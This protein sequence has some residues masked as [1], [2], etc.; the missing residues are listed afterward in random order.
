MSYFKTAIF[1][2]L[3][4][5]LGFSGLC[6]QE[7]DRERM[8]RDLII[9]G[10]ILDELFKTQW[11]ANGN[12]VRISSGSFSFGRSNHPSGT[13]LQDYGVVFTISGGPPAFLI[14]SNRDEDASSFYFQ[15]ESDEDDDKKITEES[16]IS[17]MREFLRYYSPN[18]GQLDDD[19]KV[20][21]IYENNQPDHSAFVRIFSS[22]GEKNNKHTE[23]DLPSTIYATVTR[24]DLEAVKNG[25]IS[26]SEF[27]DR[28]TIK[29][30]EEEGQQRDLKIMANILKTSL[31]ETENNAF[32]IRGSANSIYIEDLGALFFI[33][34][35]YGSG[36][37]V[38]G[39]AM[40]AVRDKISK[41]FDEDSIKSFSFD[42]TKFD[43][44]VE[45]E[46]FNKNSKD[47]TAK[48]FFNREE[49]KIKAKSDEEKK[50]AY[51]QFLQQLKETI[52]DYG[53]TLRS[54]QSDE[55]IYVSVSLSSS[56]NEL[57]DRVNLQI[58]KSTLEAMASG[59]ISRDE[60]IEQIDER[61][62]WYFGQK[63][64]A[65]KIPHV[66]VQDPQP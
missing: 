65:T 60:A 24:T 19:D 39:D 31:E 53:Q 11:E 38:L 64:S 5:T 23:S 32:K 57:P 10:D 30:I 33:D 34:A 58:K 15:Y 45:A 48:Q 21:V 1:A 50:K 41:I 63:Q 25:S 55:H 4:F 36:F 52:V 56:V 47:S 37:T 9:M 43:S 16:I 17:R 14:S 27:D 46:F 28:L 26:E 12:S 59:N 51:Q 49:F 44:R 8:A 61:E 29:T 20:T 62:W 6:A 35:S 13:Y 18:I 42:T 7:I 22:S 2:F 3:I 66:P 40:V 54:V